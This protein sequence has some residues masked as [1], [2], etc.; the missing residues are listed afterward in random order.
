MEALLEQW[1]IHVFKAL[2]SSD[3]LQL[4]SSQAIDAVLADYHIGDG[5]NGLE[6]IQRIQQ[7]RGTACPAALITADHAA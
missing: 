7:A 1:G 6:L 2:G 3:A 5:S 4:L